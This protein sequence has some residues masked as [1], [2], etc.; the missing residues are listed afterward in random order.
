M[1]WLIRK[2]QE[3]KKSAILA[4]FAFLGESKF[5]ERVSW[6][7]QF[8]ATGH[9]LYYTVILNSFK[10]IG[11]MIERILNVTEGEGGYRVAFSGST[12]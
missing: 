4:L 11:L 7:I 6:K 8:V 2:S 9:L 1:N 5:K 12:K 10:D 3:L